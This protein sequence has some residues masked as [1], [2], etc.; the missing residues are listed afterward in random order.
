MQRRRKTTDTAP[1]TLSKHFQNSKKSQRSK[2]KVNNCIGWL[3]AFERP[4]KPSAHTQKA[5]IKMF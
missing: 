1:T 4:E 3:K 5:L 2:Q